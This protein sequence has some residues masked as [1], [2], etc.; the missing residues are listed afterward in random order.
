MAGEV[1]TSLEYRAIELETLTVPGQK[2]SRNTVLNS[3]LRRP[4]LA[5]LINRII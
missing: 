4:T 1:T 3:E 2:S 5:F